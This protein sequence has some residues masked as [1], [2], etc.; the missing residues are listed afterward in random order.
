MIF[1]VVAMARNG[2][3]GLDGGLPW[4]I[5]SDLKRFKQL[6][7]GKPVVMGRK[8]WE[9]LPNGPLPGRGNVVITRQRGYDAPG[10]E[11]VASAEAALAACRGAPD[12]AV[13]GGAEIFAMFWPMVERIYLSEIDLDV[14]GDTHLPAIDPA[15]WR[16]VAREA[17]PRGERDSASFGLRTLGR[18]KKN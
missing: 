9:S 15:E 14:A 16:E 18:V 5:P 8:T 6:T 7:Q 10:A 3:I 4:R 12:I 1:Y 2:V 13:I 17:H 11:V